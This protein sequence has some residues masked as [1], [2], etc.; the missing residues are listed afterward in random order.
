MTTPD[1]RPVMATTTISVPEDL[2]DELYSRKGR[3]E[4][5]ADVIR[6]LIEQAD[7]GAATREGTD[8]SRE[9]PH[10]TP[11]SPPAGDDGTEH[12][13]PVA[14]TET[15]ADVVDDVAGEALPGSGAKLEARRDAFEAVVAYLREHGSATPADL[16]RD[17]YPDHDGGYTR[18]EDPARS[19]WKNAMYP[20][21]REL[22]DRTGDVEKADTTGTWT[23]HGE[24]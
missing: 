14:A 18:G 20:A 1:S 7:A 4:S 21:L 6:R 8:A 19:W 22:A 12:G 24:E 13:E 9:Q 3:G 2:A 11:G 17:V 10:G 5:Y 15:F 23:Y 16:R